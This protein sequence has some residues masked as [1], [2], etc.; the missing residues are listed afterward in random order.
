VVLNFVSLEHLA[1]ELFA[2]YF[3]EL[4]LALMIKNIPTWDCGLAEFEARAFDRDIVAE[5]K[6]LVHFVTDDFVVAMLAA[7]GRKRA[8]RLYMFVNLA[9]FHI[10]T[11][12]LAFGWKL[13]TSFI[14]MVLEDESLN[15]LMAVLAGDFDKATFS[16]MLLEV[17]AQYLALASGADHLNKSTD[18]GMGV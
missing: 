16:V 14:Q 7:D 8:F 4:T 17:L 3:A 2:E 13:V 5:E 6:M 11:A 9:S 18:V 1:T 15:A 10:T 12:V